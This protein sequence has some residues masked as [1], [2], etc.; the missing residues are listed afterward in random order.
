[1]KTVKGAVFNILLTEL[2]IFDR[3]AN[4]TCAAIFYIIVNFIREYVSALALLCHCTYFVDV[5]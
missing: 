4:K 5:Q 1:M 3:K 2:L